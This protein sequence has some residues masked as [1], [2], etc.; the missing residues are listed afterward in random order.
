MFNNLRVAHHAGV[1]DVKLEIVGVGGGLDAGERH[2][3]VVRAGNQH[4]ENRVDRSVARND[5]QFELRSLQPERVTFGSSAQLIPG[6]TI[7]PLVKFDAAK[8]VGH[9]AAAAR[10]REHNDPSKV[11]NFVI[12]E[13]LP[14]KDAAHGVGDEVNFFRMFDLRFQCVENLFGQFFDGCGGGGVIDVDHI[15]PFGNQ[16][17]FHFRHGAAGARESVQKYNGFVA[18][19]GDMRVACTG[20]GDQAD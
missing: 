4:G 15:V 11:W 7:N 20:E 19:R 9:L 12:F 17:L 3:A 1:G 5:A 16:R 10:W 2:L 14:Q 18:G 6:R 13:M 8:F